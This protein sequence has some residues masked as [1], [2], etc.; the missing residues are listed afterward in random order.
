M[1]SRSFVGGE[2]NM[3]LVIFNYISNIQVLLVLIIAK[4]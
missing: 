3:T 4:L 2:F 1:V